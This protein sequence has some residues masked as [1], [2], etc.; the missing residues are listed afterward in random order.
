MASRVVTALPCL[1][2]RAPWR[3]YL[4]WFHNRRPGITE[5]VL[6]RSLA[7]GS[8]ANPY[9]WLQRAV[10]GQGKV[11]DLACGSAPLAGTGGLKRW[12]GLDRSAAELARAAQ[13]GRAPLV[14]GDATALP[15]PDEAFSAVACS[16]ALMLVQP[17]S[18]VLAEMRRALAPGGQAV[19]LLPGS[20]PLS[21]RDRLRYLRALA[22]LGQ[23]RPA[24]PSWAHIAGLTRRLSRAGFRV[25]ADERARF[26]YPVRDE[27]D[28]R[29]F[30]ESL[31]APRSSDRQ[32]DR[33]VGVA[34]RWAGSTIGIPLRRLICVKTG[35]L[36]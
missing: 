24:Y 32:V 36:T 23:L 14:R 7:D 11:L 29:H 22:A 17:T 35:R 8:G 21:A 34:A 27:A 26:G 5:D 31:Y 28:A 10:A 9:G 15:F 1:A 13:L 3:E 4:D 30:V 19:F 25:V 16:M 12:V 20:V 18:A 33:A 2:R 6:S